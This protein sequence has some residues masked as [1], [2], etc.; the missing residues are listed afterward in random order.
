MNKILLQRDLFIGVPELTKI[1]SFLSDYDSTLIKSIISNFG[2][3]KNNSDSN[4]N[5]LKVIAGSLS[6]TVSLMAGLAYDA[7][8]KILNVPLQINDIYTIPNDSAWH[9]ILI[10][11]SSSYQEQGTI[12]ISATGQLTGNNTLFTQIFRTG[13]YPTKIKFVASSNTLEYEI[14]SVTS[15]TIA[16]LNGTNFNVETNKNFYING[17]FTQGKIITTKYLYQYDTYGIS[18]SLTNDAVAQNIF[19]LARVKYDG[20]TQT[21]EDFRTDLLTIN[22]T[23]AEIETILVGIITS[24]GHSDLYVTGNITNDEYLYYNNK[25]IS[26]GY[27]TDCK[28]FGDSYY[29]YYPAHVITFG[30]YS[31]NNVWQIAFKEQLGVDNPIQIAIRQSRNTVGWDNWMY[32]IKNVES[33][34]IPVTSFLTV[35]FGVSSLY[36]NLAYKKTKDGYLEIRG[37]INVSFGGIPVGVYSLFT[38]PPEFSYNPD[39]VDKQENGIIS[40]TNITMGQ[41]YV[42]M[43]QTASNGIALI[44]L[45]R[46]DGGFADGNYYINLRVDLNRY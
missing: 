24:H 17:T 19:C 39:V 29:P 12:S 23:K 35:G 34:W 27:M 45:E 21:I 1:I 42:F 44:G 13:N 8:F 10:Q 9:Y 16:Q 30:A 31:A 7:N 43:T 6:N 11:S 46:I 15:D 36:P 22:L 32:L 18:E 4:F 2:I 38:L 25:G 40:S 20:A 41:S 26:I 33:S 28:A 37:W 14:Q 3:V 5:N